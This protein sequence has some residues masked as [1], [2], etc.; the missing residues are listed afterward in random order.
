VRAATQQASITSVGWIT[1]S[2][3]LR[4]VG[5]PFNAPTRPLRT[6]DRGT[7]FG[8]ANGVASV[9]VLAFVVAG[10][11]LRSL[12]HEE[13][14]RLL[15]KILDKSRVA[16]RNAREQRA[17][18]PP[19]C[20]AF[21]EALRARTRFAV[22]MPVILALNIAVFIGM[23]FGSGALS[24]PATLI[25][26]GGSIGPRT[27]NG[28]WWRLVT[29]LFVQS[30]VLQL[31]ANV[32][33]LVSVGFMLERL[34]GPVA[35][36]VTYVVAGV[37]AGI[38]D[39]SAHQIAVHTGASGA[40]FGVYG[41]LAASVM[42]GFYRP[43]PATI[44]LAALRRLVPG[45]FLFLSCDLVTHGLRND[46]RF[47]GLVAGFVA[48]LILAAGVTYR[49]PITRRVFATVVAT[50]G[51]VIV[52]LAP[53]S[54]LDDV[55]ADIAKV[56]AFEDRTAHEYDSVLERFNQGRST[57]RD[58]IALIDQIRPQL[59]GLRARLES[60]H[61]VPREHQALVA[62]AIE[63]L[64]TRD[65]SWR[66]REEALRKS[67]LQMLREADSVERISLD[68]FKKLKVAAAS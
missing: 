68:T 58:R 22:A 21:V 41:L 6:T 53:L 11:Y 39:L 29:S 16:I 67:N 36:A 4:I 57:I 1:N 23:C 55:S 51:I 34:V 12:N 9:F 50:A 33:G 42:W 64:K 40:I 37:I 24:D 19:E 59:Q 56:I 44:P 2:V 46:A 49:K 10:L 14:A 32:I 26:W 54:S 61:K 38:A 47:A 63:Y 7:H 8:H 30:G 17:A 66:L 27:T 25:A 31:L 35:F 45:A 18:V 65:E 62:G 43:S 60:F 3:A 48:G 20:K 28:E 5:G 52:L 15:R 13:R